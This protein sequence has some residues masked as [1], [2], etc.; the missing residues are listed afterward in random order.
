L[1]FKFSQKTIK[2]LL[3]SEAS[4][5]NDVITNA[6]SL[7]DVS[8]VASL[9]LMVV[10]AGYEKFVSRFDLVQHKYKPAWMGHVDFG[11]LRLNL[12]RRSSL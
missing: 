2:L 5:S 11:D 7:I 4:N 10:F 9:V 3:S 12:L 8:L 1:L 6:L